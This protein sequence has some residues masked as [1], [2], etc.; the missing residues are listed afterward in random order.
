MPPALLAAAAA[1]LLAGAMLCLC[2]QQLLALPEFWRYAALAAGTMISGFALGAP[3]PLGM[4]FLL[5]R[6]PERAFAWAVN[7]SASVL[8]AVAAAQIA[9]SAGLHW[10]LGAALAGYALAFWAAVRTSGL[11][12]SS[13]GGPLSE[14]RSIAA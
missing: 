12:G 2:S 8:A 5:Q 13:S 11:Q 9:L 10:I 7:G 4:R 1:L 3:F 6:P 14:S